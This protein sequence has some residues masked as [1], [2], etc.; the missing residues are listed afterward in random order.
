MTVGLGNGLMV[1][2]GGPVQSR[3]SAQ[4]ER[5]VFV[6]FLVYLVSGGLAIAPSGKIYLAGSCALILAFALWYANRGDDIGY[7]K[8]ALA[9]AFT[10]SQ[11][12]A[13]FFVL[14]TAV[15]YRNRAILVPVRSLRPIYLLVLYGLASYLV[16]Q[17]VEP[18]LL[19][20]PFFMLSFFLPVVCF[21]V[22]RLEQVVAARD[23]VLG[24]FQLLLIAVAVVMAVQSVLHWGESPDWRTGGTWHAH[25]AGILVGTGFLTALGRRAMLGAAGICPRERF[26]LYAGMPLLFLA[27]AKYILVIL[28]ASVIG[29]GMVWLL[30]SRLRLIPIALSAGLLVLVVASWQRVLQTPVILSTAGVG[31]AVT[32]VEALFQGF[33]LTPRGQVLD[34]TLSLPQTEP[35]V[36]LLGSGPGTFLSRAANSRA[37]DTMQKGV[38]DQLGGELEVTSKLPK[39]I[40]PFTSWITRKYALDVIHWSTFE[41][42]SWQSGL[43]RWVSSL[44]S[45]FWEFGL[46]GFLMLMFFYARLFVAGILGARGQPPA[47]AGFALACFVPF[48]VGIAYFDL[49]LETPQ[50][51][52][53]HWAMLGLLSAGMVVKRPAP[54]PNQVMDSR[55]SHD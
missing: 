2:G 28:V 1:A 16:N 52:I 17:F 13:Y 42:Q 50:F 44:N 34:A 48:V 36:F 6:G 43:V 14:L 11:N 15:L 10:A 37:Y 35:R 32:S 12:A 5:W 54:S 4:G 41:E 46:V 26:M 31:E 19:S 21:G 51:A 3:R 8:V 53:L 55:F 38:Y 20:F 23:E 29:T 30:R 49:W 27:D 7:A 39:W 45:F 24:F 25:M 40:P 22:F 47:W 9:V 33:W 18:N